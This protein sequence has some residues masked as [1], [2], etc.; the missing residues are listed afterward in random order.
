MAETSAP[1]DGIATGDAVIAPYDAATEWAQYWSTM[2]NLDR[3]TAVYGGVAFKVLNSY[4]L[5][6]SGANINVD[7]GRAVVYGTWH[8]NTAI[9]PVAIPTP[10][11]ADR[12]DRIVLRKDWVAQTIRITRI[13]GQE[14]AGTPEPLV[15]VPGTTWD[16]PLGVCRITAAGVLTLLVE[17]YAGAGVS[18]PGRLYYTLP[19]NSGPFV[20][21]RRSTT[22]TV[23]T[24]AA[25]TNVTWEAVIDEDIDNM[26]DVGTPERITITTP[27]VYLVTMSGRF[28]P[29]AFI[30]AAELSM[31]MRVNAGGDA[32][33][34][35]QW[36][37]GSAYVANP[38]ISRHIKFQAGDFF[39]LGF[40][41]AGGGNGVFTVDL[42]S[43][44]SPVLTCKWIS[45]LGVV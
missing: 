38:F 42:D 32:V 10:A 30:A 39:D 37:Q 3:L 4:A 26:W 31:R 22:L 25:Y 36:L 15:A 41:H 1:W 12:L 20:S 34:F 18:Y 19:N 17:G 29:N 11:A 27:G 21:V 33:V 7:T 45:P 16:F 9:V 28:N 43:P 24:G 23:P 14:G 2:L 35:S 5:S 44:Y 8:Q 6:V 13:A 40:L